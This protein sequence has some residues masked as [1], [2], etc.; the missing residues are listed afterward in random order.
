MKGYR[1]LDIDNVARIGLMFIDGDKLEEV[2][3]DKLSTDYDD[4]NYHHEYFMELKTTLM[5]IEKI[6]PDLSLFAILWQLRPDNDN[7]SVPVIAGGSL[8]VE[9]WFVTPVNEEMRKV[10]RT[11]KPAVFHRS[12]DA[13]S[14]YYPV[15]NSAAEIVGV[16]ELLDKQGIRCDI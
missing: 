8:P 6:N 4:I 16:L 2:L 7:L 1:V 14:Y 10:F 11:G 15:R 9:R 13:S 5:K 3:L 12:G